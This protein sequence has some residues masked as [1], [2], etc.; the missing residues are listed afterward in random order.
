MSALIHPIATE[1]SIGLVSKENL[2]VYSVSLGSTKP[3]IKKEFERMFNTKVA[4][5][6]TVNMPNNVKKAFIK[7]APGANASDIAMKLKLV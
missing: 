3:E 7:L 6:R 2:I 1:K 5:I 4:K